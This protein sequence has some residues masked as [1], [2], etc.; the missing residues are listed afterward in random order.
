MSHR[1]PQFKY[2]KQICVCLIFQSFELSRAILQ[3]LFLFVL[4]FDKKHPQGIWGHALAGFCHLLIDLW[5]NGPMGG[6]ARRWQAVHL[7]RE[8]VAA[9]RGSIFRHLHVFSPLGRE[10][11]AAS[12]EYL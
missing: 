4:L 5:S 1:V 8:A 7:G 11:A 6:R 12:R 9:S 3:F 2:L 10:A